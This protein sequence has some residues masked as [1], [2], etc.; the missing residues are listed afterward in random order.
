MPT[1]KEHMAAD[2][3]YALADTTEAAEEFTW[4]GLT[5]TGTIIRDGQ[6][7]LANFDSVAMEKCVVEVVDT[8]FD[9]PF[10]G[11]VHDLNGFDWQVDHAQPLPGAFRISL[12]RY[13]A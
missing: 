2:L 3:A 11:S 6:G 5:Y 12:S 7:G 4:D 13:T 9:M 8:A 1:A 10:P